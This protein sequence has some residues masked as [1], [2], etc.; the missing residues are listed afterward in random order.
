MSE[1]FNKILHNPD[2]QDHLKKIAAYEVT[3][4]FCKHDLPHFLDTARIGYIINLEQKLEL[5]KDVIYAAALLH[6]IGRW[7]QYESGIQHALA[8]AIL[9]EKLLIEAGYK[10]DEI[11]EIK[12]AISNHSTAVIE[13]EHLF[14]KLL[15]T[16]DKASR[17]CYA[18]KM[19]KECDWT[20]KK[21]NNN[22]TY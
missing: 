12:K 17:G 2:Y 8:S 21:K 7:Q 3:R 5:P 9:C 4:L 6:D 20:L 14:S 19:E 11:I 1:R 22:I 10:I 16:A 13:E 18:C 15:Y